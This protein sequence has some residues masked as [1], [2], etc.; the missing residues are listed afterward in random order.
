MPDNRPAFRAPLQLPY[1]KKV[2]YYEPL[3]NFWQSVAK[4]YPNQKNKMKA[5]YYKNIMEQLQ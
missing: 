5:T 3:Y 1:Q 2:A 4:K